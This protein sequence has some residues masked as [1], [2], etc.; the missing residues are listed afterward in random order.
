MPPRRAIPT[1][2]F[3]TRADIRRLDD[4]ITRLDGKV[5]TA[6]N[7]IDGKIDA[8]INR[9]SSSRLLRPRALTIWF[10]NCFFSSLPISARSAISARRSPTKAIDYEAI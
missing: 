10:L 5:E 7:R 3:A 1:I 9:G 6:I 4:A 2:E 8:A